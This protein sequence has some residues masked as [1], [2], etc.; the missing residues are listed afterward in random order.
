[1]VEGSLL[2]VV[3]QIFGLFILMNSILKFDLAYLDE[4]LEV[5]GDLIGSCDLFWEFSFVDH[6]LSS[7]ERENQDLAL[8]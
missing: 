8:G 2:I 5:I 6:P 3:D 4:I 1:M 7:E